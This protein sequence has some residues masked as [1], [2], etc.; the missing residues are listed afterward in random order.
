MTTGHDRIDR[1]VDSLKDDP[2][3]LGIARA[4]ARPE[5]A[6]NLIVVTTWDGG[7]SLPSELARLA[8]PLVGDGPRI[9]T[10]EHPAPRHARMTATWT[11]LGADGTRASVGL[12]RA[13]DLVPSLDGRE[14]EALHDPRGLIETWKRYSV[15]ATD[16][17]CRGD[18][19]T[20]AATEQHLLVDWALR[21]EQRGRE[22]WS[23]AS[24]FYIRDARETLDLANAAHAALA[25]RIDAYVA[26][27]PGPATGIRAPGGDEPS[28]VLERFLVV[29][30][31]E[32]FK[33]DRVLFGEAVK[34]LRGLAG[35]EPVFDQGF[36]V[37]T[38]DAVE[39]AFV[40]G[41][42]LPGAPRLLPGVYVGV[43]VTPKDALEFWAAPFL[44]DPACSVACVDDTGDRDVVLR[45]AGRDPMVS[46][47]TT[48][49]DAA[50]AR[51][52]ALVAAAAAAESVDSAA[53]LATLHLPRS[54]VERAKARGSGVGTCSRLDL[55]LAVARAGH[56]C[57]PLV[58][59]KL[60]L[61]AGRVLA[62]R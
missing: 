52:P 25:A 38:F 27:S 58:A 23:G 15:K 10:L 17:E 3:V 62:N 41:D 30:D 32:G 26:R 42:A 22:Q 4:A 53:V 1:F 8:G 12:R 21:D 9:E 54:F 5:G 40:T 48:A 56:D 43:G 55:A 44:R 34:H 59:R 47:L 31:G 33:G 2:R 39:A 51:L 49:I 46:A 45:T 29:A 14:V 7:E 24:W 36:A 60:G 16:G 6:T 13:G 28:G 11:A 57:A 37:P 20:F 35:R 50:W 18:E 61:A 19:P